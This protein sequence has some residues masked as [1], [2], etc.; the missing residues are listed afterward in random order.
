MLYTPVPRNRLESDA[1]PRKPQRR[2]THAQTV[3]SCGERARRQQMAV[4]PGLWLHCFLSKCLLTFPACLPCRPTPT[5]TAGGLPAAVSHDPVLPTSLVF[6]LSQHRCCNRYCLYARLFVAYCIYQRKC[7]AC[8]RI[9]GFNAGVEGVGGV[10]D[11][12]KGTAGVDGGVKSDVLL[13]SIS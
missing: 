11:G 5:S 2:H 9:S 6:V 1:I 10:V 3:S 4:V 7:T 13:L 12:G 8:F